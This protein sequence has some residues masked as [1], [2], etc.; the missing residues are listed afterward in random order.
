MK[1]MHIACV[2]KSVKISGNRMGI[3]H[4]R[5]GGYALGWSRKSRFD[6]RNDMFGLREIA[7]A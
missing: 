4:P 5:T 2:E 7:I 1:R 6:L 3:I